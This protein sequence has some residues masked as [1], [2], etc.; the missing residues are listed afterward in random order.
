MSGEHEG[1]DHEHDGHEHAGIVEQTELTWAARRFRAIEALLE[2]KGIC[3]WQD[4]T[5]VV[6]ETEARSP[7][8]GARVVARAW[9]DPEFKQRL[10]ANPEEAIT[11]IGIALPENGARIEVFENTEDAH[12]V[13]VCTLC[14]CYPRTLLG[15]PPDWYKSLNYRSRAV[16]DPRGVVR[17]FGLEIPNDVRVEVHDSTADLRYL[18]L[19]KRPEG[20]EGWSE[21][22][23]AALVTRD[24]MIGVTEARSPDA[25]ASAG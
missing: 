13:V 22:A 17:E 12:H 11:S 10:L 9:T 21:E 6:Q 19:P 16:V 4:I 7:A 3:S 14:S 5:D 20:T 1:H 25:V 23:L 24:S 2:E 15:R 18:I 8:D